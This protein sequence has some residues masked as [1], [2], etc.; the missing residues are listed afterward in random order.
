[1]TFCQNSE[2]KV[3]LQLFVK[4]YDSVDDEDNRQS[5]RDVY[6]VLLAQQN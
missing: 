6:I 2:L 4:G 1:M 5:D 3:I